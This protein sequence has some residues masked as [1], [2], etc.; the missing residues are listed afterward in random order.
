MVVKEINEDKSTF[1]MGKYQDNWPFGEINPN[2]REIY[3]RL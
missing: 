1:S 3:S 2:L